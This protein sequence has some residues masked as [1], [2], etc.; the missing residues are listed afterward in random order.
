MKYRDL[1]AS[2]LFAL[3]LALG[4]FVTQVAIGPP[5]AAA[6][7]APEKIA[8]PA[9][10]S[11]N[12]DKSLEAGQQAAV[13]LEQAIKIARGAFPVPADFDKFTNGFEQ[14]EQGSFW[15]LHWNRSAKTGGYFDVRVNAQT[16]EIWSMSQ[17]NPSLDGS[18]Y[19]GLPAY[20]REQAQ[21]IAAALAERLQPSRFQETRLQAGRDYFPPLLSQTRSQ[22]EYSYRFARVVNGFP[23]LE[24]SINVTVNGDTGEVTG[25]N[26]NWDDAASFPDPSGSISKPAAEQIFRTQ[27]S[28]QLYYFRPRIPGGS[29]VPIKLVYCLPDQRSQLLIDALTGK[30]LDNGNYY[31]LYDGAGGAGMMKMPS[32]AREEYQL[33][34]VEVSAVEGAKNLLTQDAALSKAKAAVNV[35]GEYALRSSR[36]EQDYLFTDQKT[37]HFSWE[38]GTEPD[39]KWLDI[40]V[41]AASG[42]LVSFNLNES[43]IWDRLGTT[44]PKFSEADARTVAES[45]IKEAQPE[46]WGQVVFK[47]AQPVMGP[48]LSEKQLPGAYTFVWSRVARDGIQFPDNGFTVDVN[49]VTGQITGFRMNWYDVDFPDPQ[50]VMDADAAAGVFLRE[51]PLTEAYL[52]LWPEDRWKGS[53]VKA[54]IYLTYHLNNQNFTMLDAFSGQPLNSEGE[55]V[56]APSEGS[57]FTDLAGSPAREAVEMLADAGIISAAGGLFRPNDAVTQAELIAMLVKAGTYSEGGVRPLSTGNNEAWYQPYYEQAVQLGILQKGEQP[58]PDAPVTR[59][60]MARWSIH[61]IGLYRVARL[62]DIY[63]LDF[64]D[65]AEIPE[66]LRGHAAISVAMGLL[67][68]RE[69]YFRPQDH[70]SRGEAAITLV[71][72]LNSWK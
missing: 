47:D 31:V 63:V 8:A 72:L 68:P 6:A 23:Y 67:E 51:A 20:S 44:E 62:S 27:A 22:V 9:Q 55:A 30:I 66:H 56:E 46:K 4:F 33:N 29:E 45:F 64:Q 59:I 26:L 60:F 3:V 11:D 5:Q 28:P 32:T 15:E 35:T 17:W 65:A 57:G 14:S 54:E 71:K 38:A 7:D 24:N 41:D 69:G 12:N 61:A 21:G 50:G 16:G 43:Y 39:R 37:W 58:D 2:R 40:S 53:T 18:G 70:V 10:A 1:V 25:F 42:E 49:A 13:S 34:P 52:G 19:Q 48:Y 36:I